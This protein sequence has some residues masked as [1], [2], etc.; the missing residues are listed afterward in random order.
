MQGITLSRR[1]KAIIGDSVKIVYRKAVDD[2][3]Y[4]TDEYTVIE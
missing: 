1:L 2:P 4:E 3:N